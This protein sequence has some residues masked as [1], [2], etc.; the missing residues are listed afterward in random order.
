[1]HR[2]R[3]PLAL[4]LLLAVALDL[5]A[6]LDPAQLA[7]AR[8]LYGLRKDPEA[9]AAYEKLAA[10]DPRNAEAQHY[11]GLLAMRRDDSETAVKFLEAAVALNPGS[12]EYHRRYGDACGRT[13]QK[14]GVLAKLGWARKCRLAYEKAVELDPK[15][16]DARFS[17]MGFY[18]QA[19]G[20][21]GGGMD[22][23]YAQAGEIRKL[24]PA[25]G[26]IAFAN[27]YVSDK[28]YSEAFSLYQETL[29]DSPDD[30]SAL[31]QTG[32][33]A[34]DTGERLDHGL[35]ALRTCLAQTPPADQPGH[36]AAHWRIGVIQEKQNDKAA[37]RASYETALKLDPSFRRAQESLKNLK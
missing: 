35:A 20:I 21:A 30:Y 10:A 7:A 34:A 27:L 22:K 33:L 24:D 26:R 8:E 15:S 9:R 2:F 14:A 16:L 28:K 13:A 1:M 17:L 23:A 19:P 37:A 36:A 4:P 12:G 32:R 18:Q 3:L 11:L 6:A 5:S 29:K 25:R 31:Y